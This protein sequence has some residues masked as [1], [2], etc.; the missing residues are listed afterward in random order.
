M[1]IK[2]G[3]DPEDEQLYSRR[4]FGIQL[5]NWAAIYYV[6]TTAESGILLWIY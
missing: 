3:K 5:E 1:G 2:L 6:D 4:L